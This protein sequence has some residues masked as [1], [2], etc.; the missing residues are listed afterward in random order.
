MQGILAPS[1]PY[2]ILARVYS[3]L[4]AVHLFLFGFIITLNPSSMDL[5]Q[6]QY[7]YVFL[8]RIASPP[9]WGTLN[10]VAGF[11]RLAALCAGTIAPTSPLPSFMVALSTIYGVVF[12]VQIMVGAFHADSLV[13]AITVYMLFFTAELVNLYVSAL[14]SSANTKVSRP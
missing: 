11:M 12:W 4:M 9:T 3:A 6:R 1:S 14:E 2:V 7:L 13:P 5:P 10:M 8:L